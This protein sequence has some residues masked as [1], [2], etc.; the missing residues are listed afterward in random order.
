MIAMTNMKYR[1]YATKYK[2][3]KQFSFPCQTQIEN[4]LKYWTNICEITLLQGLHE[5]YDTLS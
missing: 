3:E 4:G 1:D 2:T 5:S